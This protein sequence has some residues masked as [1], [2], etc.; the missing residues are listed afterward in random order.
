[1]S[2]PLLLRGPLQQLLVLVLASLLMLEAGARADSTWQHPERLD[3]GVAAF[4]NRDGHVYVGWRLLASDPQDV[5]FEV[6][7]A[8][9]I[10]GPRKKISAAP[11]ADSTNFVDETANGEKFFYSI[12]ALVKGKS[13][14]ESDPVGM[15]ELAGVGGVRKIK[16]QGA[17]AAQKIG[18]GDFNGN[19]K[20]DF[21]I[22][23]PDFNTDPYQMPGYWK[24]SL[25]PYKLEAYSHEGEFLWRHDL[26]WAIE[27][28]IWYSPI[29]VYDLD[30][31]GKAEVYCKAGPPGDPRIPRGMVL[32]GPEYLVKLDGE[33]GQVL[34]QIDWPDRSGMGR[35]DSPEKPDY[36]YWSRNMLGIAYLDGKRPHLIVLRG[37]YTLIKIRAYDPGLNLV[38]SFDSSGDYEPIKGAGTHGLQI[39]DV[40]GDGRDELIIGAAAINHDGTPLWNTR[41]GHP[42][43]CYVADID[44]DRPGLEVFFGH[45]WRQPNNGVCVVDARTGETIWGYEGPTTHVH[46]Q[47]M[48]ADI[49][50]TRPGMEVYGGE[51]DGSQFWL[52]DAKGNRLSDQSFGKGDLSPRA[53]WW[54]DKTHKLI[55]SR[56]KMFEYNGPEYGEIR[57]KIIGIA[58]VFGDWR[59]E[60]IVSVEGEI[61]IYSTT[62][63]AGSRRPSLLQDRQYRTAVAHQTMGYFYPPTLGKPLF[64]KGGSQ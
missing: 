18:L 50:P 15:D 24:P 53:V 33:T 64:P 11:I 62:I 61:H 37:T 28:G 1:M 31:D 5:A 32:S 60:L 59:E 4:P 54:T 22:K 44:P 39:A 3:R 34:A 19:G 45:E 6:Y 21:L 38:W 51:R 23:Q 13:I 40:D 56:G 57:G 25:E 10:D 55:V 35:R 20:L 42:D 36:N 29:V 12:R 27:T 52:Y 49:D 8:Q 30:G 16:L 26:G 47:G 41:R 9:T 43:V 63:P 46:G 58:D 48:V 14:G 17:Y 2:T 7:R